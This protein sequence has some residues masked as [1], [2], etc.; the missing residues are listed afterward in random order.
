MKRILQ[1][2]KEKGNITLVIDEI[3]TLVGAGAAEG[4]VDAANLLKPA[5]AR[6]S[7]RVIVQLLLVS[8]EDILKKIQH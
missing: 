8:I 6:G 2:V 4:A 1:E 5:L 3:H 7:L